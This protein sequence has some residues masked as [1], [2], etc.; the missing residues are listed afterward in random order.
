MPDTRTPEEKMASPYFDRWEFTDK[1]G[2]PDHFSHVEYRGN[3]IQKALHLNPVKMYKVAH[4]RPMSHEEMAAV[5]FE[6]TRAGD[7]YLPSEGPQ[8]VW[9]P[10]ES[11]PGA[12]KSIAYQQWLKDF[13]EGSRYSRL[14]VLYKD[15]PTAFRCVDIKSR[16]ISKFPWTL[17]DDNGDEVNPDHPIYQRLL[18]MNPESNF[19]DSIR[20]TVSDLN[21]YGRA[22]WR[23]I[24]SDSGGQLL[25]YKRV[26]PGQ[27][28]SRV[29]KMGEVSYF[30]Q[31]GGKNKEPIDREDLM[32]WRYYDPESDVD[33]VSPMYA[34]RIP[35]RVEINA[36]KQMDAFFENG[37][38]PDV[39]MALE[40][41]DK[42][43][44]KS[45]QQAWDHNHK[46]VSRS[47]KTTFTGG[48][49][50]PHL[51]GYAPKDLALTDVHSEARK[52]ICAPFGVPPTMVA[53]IEAA[54]Y[55]T[56]DMSRK[57]LITETLIPDADYIA[58]VLTEEADL[59]GLTFVWKYDELEALA[60]ERSE[61]AEWVLK[62][63]EQ[64]VIDTAQAAEEL[65]FEAPS[66]TKTLDLRR[67]KGK[68]IK[69]LRAGKK[70]PSF[71]SEFLTVAQHQGIQAGLA[72][73]TTEEEIAEV[74]D[75]AR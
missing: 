15:S 64:G 73:A 52:G 46:G 5:A 14:G 44:I 56:A 51:V 8:K 22:F 37:S 75:S 32:L 21:I 57:S 1:Q 31:M 60:E 7:V 35:A 17:V 2:R 34:A 66:A 69:A 67:W 16:M 70:P 33:G 10:D 42:N 43:Q 6:S 18:N 38:A 40:T 47:H 59:E 4:Y 12:L 30:I 23:K 3:L 25:F 11:K 9:V 65:G 28:E 48:N 55:A 68:A 24:R 63:V 49:A 45:V 53:A 72:S 36:N 29:N 39:I 27:I 61:K 58:S 13:F 50:K 41:T 20:D 26:N 19:V 54:N 62:A 74:F 71:G